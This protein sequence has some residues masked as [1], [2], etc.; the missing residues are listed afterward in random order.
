MYHFADI[1]LRIVRAISRKKD[2]KK[3]LKNTRLIV[4]EHILPT[5]KEFL[6]ILMEA[7]AEIFALIAKPYSIDNIVYNKL[8]KDGLNIIKIKSYQELEDSDI[9]FK[10][11]YDANEKSKKDRKPIAIIDVGGYFALPLLRFQEEIKKTKTD[12]YIKGIIEDT[13][14]GHNR[15][16]NLVEKNKITIPI[17]SVARSELKRIEARFVGRD[18]VQAMDKMLREYGISITGRNALVIGYGMIGKN[19]ARTLRSYDLNV[20][21]YD[22]EDRK[23][24]RAFIDGFHIHKKVILLRHADIIFSA[25]GTE[26]ANLKDDGKPKFPHAL[27]YEEIEDCKHGVILAS[28]GSKDTEFDVVSIK[29]NAIKKPEKLNINDSNYSLTRYSLP[30]SKHVIVAQEGTAVNFILPSLPVEI[31]DL[32][33][34]EILYNLLEL[35]QDRLEPGVVNETELEPLNNISKA[36]LRLV[37]MEAQA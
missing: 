4:L 36:W 17:G 35:L 30:N 10:L 18:A 14:F 8:K 16:K 22:I 15:Y 6:K 5:T 37:N 1:Q 34:S 24:L 33:F 3:L 23:L 19:V 25:T 21:V 29:Q 28:V 27:T 32:V 7:G 2:H 13:T 9:C 20:Y 26:A 12:N 11:L 31:L